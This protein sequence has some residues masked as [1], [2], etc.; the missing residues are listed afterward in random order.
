MAGERRSWTQ[1]GLTVSKPV[2]LS[3]L[4]ES[5]VL[6]LSLLPTIPAVPESSLQVGL[7]HGDPLSNRARVNVTQPRGEQQP[8]RYWSSPT[9]A[10]A[11][12]TPASPPEG[13][14]SLCSALWW[15]LCLLES[16]S[17][18]RFPY[19]PPLW[20]QACPQDGVQHPQG[21]GGA[22]SG[23]HAQPSELGPC[24]SSLPASLPVPCWATV[25]PESLATR[26]GPIQGLVLSWPPA[27]RGAGSCSP[28]P[29]TACLEPQCPFRSPG[30]QD[31]TCLRPQP[32]PGL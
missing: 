24:F 22:I 6:K 29:L 12:S 19:C 23:E 30:P 15:L 2:G 18:S 13:T 21:V 9:A 1:A 4:R 14:P 5:S 10:P 16:P 7:S 32:R 17:L 31:Q 11:P 20:S 8:R 3:C 28:C 26:L 25:L 27:L